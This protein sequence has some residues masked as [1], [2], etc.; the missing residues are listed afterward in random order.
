VE[1][2]GGA[3]REE[4]PLCPFG[5][6][7]EFLTLSKSNSPRE[8]PETPP[9]SCSGGVLVLANDSRS[10]RHW[11]ARTYHITKKRFP[12]YEAAKAAEAYAR[13]VQCIGV[14]SAPPLQEAGFFWTTGSES[15]IS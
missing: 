8:A 2:D 6:S 10:A 3:F 1:R 9:F 13:D 7:G 14:P 4:Y 11:S 5:S 15:T 12:T